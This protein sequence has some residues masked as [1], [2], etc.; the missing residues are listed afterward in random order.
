VTDGGI[1][2]CEVRLHRNVRGAWLTTN[3]S[4]KHLE[5]VRGPPQQTRTSRTLLRCQHENDNDEDQCA[6]V[7]I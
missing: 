6:N 1:V 2:A 3:V 5:P 4:C 7:T